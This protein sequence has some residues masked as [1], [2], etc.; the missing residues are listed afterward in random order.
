MSLQTVR[1]RQVGFGGS[2]SPELVASRLE[3]VDWY[4]PP[5][6]A[7][8]FLGATPGGTGHGLFIQ[9]QLRADRR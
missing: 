6:V 4:D 3:E 1:I 9:T 5:A 7:A 8:T 2:K